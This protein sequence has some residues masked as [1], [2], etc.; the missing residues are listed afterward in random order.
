LLQQ[1]QQQRS[2]A[3]Q[4]SVET[5]QVPMPG[6]RIVDIELVARRVDL[7]ALAT[8][9]RDIGITDLGQMPLQKVAIE[10]MKAKANLSGWRSKK[11]IYNRALRTLIDLMV[12]STVIANEDELE[13]IE[14]LKPIYDRHGLFDTIIPRE[15]YRFDAR[16]TGLRIVAGLPELWYKRYQL[17]GREYYFVVDVSGSMSGEETGYSRLLLATVV[18][19]LIALSDD[20]A[21]FNLVPFNYGVVD[22][23]EDLDADKFVDM[24]LSL[25]PGGGTNYVAAILYTLEIAKEGSVVVIIGDF[26]DNK[27]LPDECLQNVEKKNLTVV[28][29]VPSVGH[30]SYAKYIAEALKGK[31]YVFDFRTFK[32]LPI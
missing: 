29:I 32:I 27:M 9:L 2:G 6:S 23:F 7:D 12:V 8:T 15:Q 24:V 18:A 26:E 10:V 21:K 4:K 30:H 14:F 11:T 13:K 5:Q 3:S 22:V 20:S 31:A 1:L 28:T 25:T 17:S 19:S 16:R